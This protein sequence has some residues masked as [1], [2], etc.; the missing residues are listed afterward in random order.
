M[1]RVDCKTVLVIGHSAFSAQQLL[2]AVRLLESDVR[3]Q[4]VFTTAPDA[5]HSGLGELLTAHRGVFLPWQR[6]IIERFDLALAADYGAVHE[7]R[8]PLMVLPHGTSANQIFQRADRAVGGGVVYGLDPQRLIRG[9]RVPPTMILLSHGAELARLARTRPEI[10]PLAGVIG[11]SSYDRLIASLPLRDFYRRALGVGPGQKLVVVAA[12]AGRY[13]AASGPSELLHRVAAELPAAEFHVLVLFHPGP[14][15]S[16]RV[17]RSA[18]HCTGL[19][20]LPPETD[21]RAPLVA[22]DLIIS[23][24]GPVAPYGAVVGIPVLLNGIQ[25]NADAEVSSSLAELAKIAPRLTSRHSVRTQLK[26]AA[27][28]Y[29]PDHYQTVVD[30]ITSEPGRCNRILR[31]LM[32]RMLDLPQPRTIPTTD[33]VSPPF[34]IE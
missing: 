12:T 16:R 3:I 9:H 22:A 8:A 34:R 29:R 13:S 27:K 25:N 10:L 5:T 28:K 21:W 26:K 32:Y 20:F 24:A 6:A 1:T 17:G 18:E 19:S 31:K 7:V 14:T 30:R 11:D 4:V 23:D 2:D 33:P 15:P